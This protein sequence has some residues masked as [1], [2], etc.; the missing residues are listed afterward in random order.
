VWWHEA[1]IPR[2]GRLKLGG[3]QFQ[4]SPGKK[5]SLNSLSMEKSWAWWYMSVI[6][7]MAGSIK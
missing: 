4:V 2:Y 5:I 3:L 7:V 6:P 1:V